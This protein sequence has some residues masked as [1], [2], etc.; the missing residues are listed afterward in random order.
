MSDRLQQA[1]TVLQS[2]FGSAAPHYAT[3]PVPARS[4]GIPELDDLT[5]IGGWPVG[6]LS[7]LIGRR[8][9]GKRTLALRTVAFATQEG[10]TV[11]VDTPRRLDADMV[12]RLGGDLSRL[13][14]VRPKNMR[15][16]LESARILARAGASMVCFD[17]SA[18]GGCALDA[19]LPQ[20][21]H[22]AEEAAC[23]ALF[24]Q[25]AETDAAALRFYASLV[26]ALQ[27]KAWIFRPDGDLL[28]LDLEAVTV[29]NRLAP[30]GRQSRWILPYVLP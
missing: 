12:Y 2:R 30:P 26:V 29:K 25:D 11:Y 21:V 27:R 3:A 18:G 14:V 24:V 22:R 1:I 15:E 16:G 9:S 5:G 7:L 4:S 6:R 19:E 20:L 8:G 10:M 13:L 23:I 28:G 17:L